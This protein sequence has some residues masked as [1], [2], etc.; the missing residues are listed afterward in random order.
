MATPMTS[1]PQDIADVV[2]FLVSDE[3]RLVTGHVVPVDGRIMDS[4]P[5]VA[6]YRSWMDSRTAVDTSSTPA[7]PAGVHR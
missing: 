1:A 3:A 6:D 7:R 5:I 4:S 2:A